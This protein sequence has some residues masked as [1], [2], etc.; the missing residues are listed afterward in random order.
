MIRRNPNGDYPKID[1]TAYIDSSVVII[2]NVSI[3]KNVFVAPGAVI[4]A[5]ET[6]SSV[7]V[8]DSSNIQDRVIIHA[9][10][11]SSVIIG[12]NTSLS[13]G[14]IVHGPCKI[15][16]ECFIGFGSVVFKAILKDSVFVKSLAVI[17]GV[18]IPDKKFIPNGAII[19]LPRTVESLRFISKEEIVFAN[20]VVKANLRLAKGYKK[21]E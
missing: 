4:R 3:G 15:G 14:C 20:K 16:K 1:K 8:G 7:S 11:N 13:H 18:K 19:S 21:E 10:G 2:G 6:G 12:K 9:L 5:D 17:E